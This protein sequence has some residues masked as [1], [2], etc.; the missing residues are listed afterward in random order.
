MAVAEDH[1]I[2]SIAFGKYAV[3]TAALHKHILA[4]SHVQHIQP[5]IWAS[6]LLIN[7]NDLLNVF[8]QLQ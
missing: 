3:L 2:F 4:V 5:F 1:V 7:E 6:S 8:S